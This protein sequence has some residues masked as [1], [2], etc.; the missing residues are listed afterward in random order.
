MLLNTLSI[1]GIHSPSKGKTTQESGD[2]PFYTKE[3]YNDEAFEYEKLIMRLRNS[4]KLGQNK[5]RSVLVLSSIG[6]DQPYGE[7]RTLE[8]F[9]LTIFTLVENQPKYDF[10]LGLLNNF[11]NEVEK[12]KHYI[13]K[14][15]EKM[16][17]Y[18][19]KITVS[20]APHLEDAGGISRESRHDDSKQRLRRRLI[21]RSR[22]FLMSESLENEQYIL[23][24]DSDI[25]SFDKQEMFI[26]VMVKS[27]KD[28]IVPRIRKRFGLT[29]YDRNS[30]RGKRTK[31][32]Q[33]QLDIM[34]SNQWDKFDYVPKDV[35]G[36]IFHFFHLDNTENEELKKLDHFEPLDSVGGAVLF[37]KSIIYRQGVIFPTSYIVGTTWDRLEGY[38]GIETEGI[39]Y[40]AKPLGYEC[41]GMPNLSAYHIE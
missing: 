32:T 27:E 26:D 30:W 5:K 36:E 16:S 3:E 23:F 10:S 12:I 7:G 19:N 14:N 29:D 33:E 39:C 11:P 15:E 21:A 34:D 41:W 24:M 31:P 18:F 37:F 35:P 9:F 22:N 6:K 40:L 17:K 13:T 1:S 38:D 4:G 28:I 2:S 8:Q 20:S 25:V